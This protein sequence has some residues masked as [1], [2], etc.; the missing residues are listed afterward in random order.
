M[1]PTEFAFLALGLVLGIAV[2][3]AVA[4][5]VR[6]RPA[7]RREVRLTVAPNSIA[8]RRA[9]TLSSEDRPT[10]V[11]PASGGPAADAYPR[12]SVTGWT[13]SAGAASPTAGA[14]GAMRTP[15][16]SA[17]RPV[18]TPQPQ[19]DPRPVATPA[20]WGPSGSAAVPVGPA[21][22]P[23]A[24]PTAPSPD[25]GPTARTAPF[26][27][28]RDP[29]PAVR[30]AQDRAAG[31][32]VLV[33]PQVPAPVTGP[34]PAPAAPR[35]LPASLD[36]GGHTGHREVRVRPAAAP[37]GTVALPPGAVGVPIGTG[38]GPRATAD[39][40]TPGDGAGT[41]R[42]AAAPPGAAEDPTGPSGPC[43]DERRIANE[44]CGL[45]GHAR[46]Q[47]QAAADALREAQRAYDAV[48]DR[49]DLLE[50]AADPREVRAAKDAAHL[51]F[52]S[53]RRAAPDGHAA[54]EAA[55][56]WLAEINRL[57]TEAYAA[58]EALAVDR[59]ALVASIPRL[60]RLA[61]EADAARIAAETA[62]AG[63]L[64]ARELLAACEEA[65]AQAARPPVAPEKPEPV[66]AGWPVSPDPG[67][68][69]PALGASAAGANPPRIL[70]L[71]RGDRA[72]REA[73]VAELAGDD[74]AEVRAW[75]LALANLVDAI[76]ARAIEDGYLE[77]S[78]R[79][80][81]WAM[82][83]PA[84][85]QAIVSALSALGFRFDGLGGFAD[86][87][88][89]A[90]RDL[91][92]AVG[93]AGLDR[94]RVRRWPREEEL[95]DLFVDTTVAADAWLVGAA[96]DL[97]LGRMV[98]ALGHRAADLADVWNAWG[99]LRPRLLATD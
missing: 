17:G 12:P 85:R 60:E 24:R 22:A 35:P 16:P 96:D 59:E 48:R 4:E 47:A 52:R 5:I 55:R 56:T 11:F 18:M 88:A 53:A 77:V 80:P 25:A 72:T 26:T 9:A 45:A 98:D 33:P 34:A 7:P 79:V 67:I 40:P 20:P 64:E 50:R 27:L 74:P 36:V 93:Y 68:D 95:P 84:E 97:A 41:R 32:A 90:P 30:Q 2:G 89:P 70:R 86:D 42:P 44:R 61:L 49:V 31:V 54:E 62:D 51:A 73:L 57:N 92:L 83:E 63:C 6:A 75:R 65:A 19:G 46:G 91:S 81:F 99:R 8:P 39:V 38:A 14:P 82:F 29:R 3:A 23:R 28:D 94:M 76:V 58:R 71:L 37:A 1:S 21:A 43:A 10:A 13:A 87:R 15:V 78:D 69:H 66:V